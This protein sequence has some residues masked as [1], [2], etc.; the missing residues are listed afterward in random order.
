MSPTDFWETT[1][2]EFWACWSHKYGNRKKGK[3][4]EEEDAQEMRR[5]LDEQIAKERA[6]GIYG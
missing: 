2:Q 5:K 3:G 6:Q 4:L 1:P